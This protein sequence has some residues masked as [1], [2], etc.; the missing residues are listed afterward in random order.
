ML[1]WDHMSPA[2][3]HSDKIFKKKNLWK[4]VNLDK[5]KSTHH[6]RK[7]KNVNLDD[8]KSKTIIKKTWK[9]TFM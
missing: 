8:T 1:S 7:S 4:N 3:K 6:K 9:C 2:L 5:K